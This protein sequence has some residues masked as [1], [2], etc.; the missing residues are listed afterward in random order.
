MFSLLP[1]V[2]PKTH[3]RGAIKS[4]FYFSSRTRHR[5]TTKKMEETFDVDSLLPYDTCLVHGPR[6]DSRVDLVH[7]LMLYMEHNSTEV[8]IF[9]NPKEGDRKIG[10]VYPQQRFDRYSDEWLNIIYER[11]RARINSS[12]ASISNG[13]SGAHLEGDGAVLLVFDNCI[14]SEEAKNSELLQKLFCSGRFLRIGIIVCTE[15]PNDCTPAV[16]ANI[17]HVLRA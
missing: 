1:R 14:G 10:G 7:M 11:Q 17:T 5:N 4:Y 9:G 15:D 3:A 2:I 12:N 16:R 6:R 8:F 13:T